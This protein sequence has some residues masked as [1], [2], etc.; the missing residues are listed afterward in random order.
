MT[1]IPQ[2]ALEVLAAFDAE[3]LTPEVYLDALLDRCAQTEPDVRAWSHLDPSAARRE[4]AQAQ[5]TGTLRGLPL[6]VKDL[7]HVTSMPRGCG[8]PIYTGYVSSVDA[9]VVALARLAGAYVMG[10][11][12]TTEFATYKPAP[13]RNPTSLAHTPGGSSSGSAAAVAAGMVPLAFGSQTAGSVI[14]PAAYC[15]VVGYKPSFDLIDTSGVKGLSRSFDTIGVFARSVPDAALLVESVTGQPFLEATQ[16]VSPPSVLG[17]CQSPAWDEIEPE[18]Q[19]AWD[20]LCARLQTKTTTRDIVLPSP[21]ADALQA[22]PMIMAQ[23]AFQALAYEWQAHRDHLSPALRDML[24]NGQARTGTAHND[25][26]VMIST[27]KARFEAD[28]GNTP[29]FITPSAPGAAPGYETGT[30][31]PV[32]NRLWTLLGAPC[33]NVPG[34]KTSDQRPLGIQVVGPIGRDAEVLNVATWLADILMDDG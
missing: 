27:L 11:T 1:S 33:V 25:D 24:A 10:K 3:T 12:E 4:L 22:H 15:G 7:F 21:Y 18:M 32:F 8:S 23:E 6:G 13:T 14:R 20:H 34:L 26:R 9:S 16:N 29:I 28:L 19:S 2:T 17:L 5:R 30:G 31:S